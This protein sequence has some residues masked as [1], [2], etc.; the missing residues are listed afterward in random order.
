MHGTARGT[1]SCHQRIGGA[2]PGS[3]GL[4]CGRW[5]G[6]WGGGLP[7]SPRAGGLAPGQWGAVCGLALSQVGGSCQAG[8]GPGV[9]GGLSPG[10]WGTDPHRGIVPV[11]GQG[12]CVGLGSLHRALAVPRPLSLGFCPQ[13]PEALPLLPVSSPR[14]GAPGGRG[15]P[16]PRPH[17][18]TSPCPLVPSRP[19][20]VPGPQPT[21]TEA[22]SPSPLPGG[23][24]ARGL[25]EGAGR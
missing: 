9:S 14:C 18:P 11:W 6:G 15:A 4:R 16:S 2:G 13:A 1:G 10:C 8:H 17:V 12:P 23:G 5:V 22:P 3:L 25:G 20:R 21:V 19:P 24:R 7:K